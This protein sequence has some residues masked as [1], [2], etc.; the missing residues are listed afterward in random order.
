MRLLPLVAVLVLFGLAP[1]V[2]GQEYAPGPGEL[3]VLDSGE[4]L[5]RDDVRG[6]RKSVV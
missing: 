6:D 1:G 3:E 5:L 2:S 4:F